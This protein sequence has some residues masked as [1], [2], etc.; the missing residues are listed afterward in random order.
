MSLNRQRKGTTMNAARNYISLIRFTMKKERVANTS[1][2]ELNRC[3][4]NK[5]CR[6]LLNLAKQL[7]TIGMLKV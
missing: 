1:N 2:K 6:D 7:R 5:N 4:P 3:F